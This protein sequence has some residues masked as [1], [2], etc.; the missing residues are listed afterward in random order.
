MW[1]GRFNPI[2]VTDREDELRRLVDLFRVDLLWPI[3]ET[4]DNAKKFLQK[5]PY[6]I[7]PFIF[8]SPF[9]GEKE[10]KRAQLLDIHNMLVYLRDKPEWEALNTRGLRVYTWKSDDPLA[11]VF[12]IQLGAYPDPKE[13]GIEY[14]EMLTEA[15][16]ATEHQLESETP[17]PAQV[18]DHPNIASLSRHGLKQHY[19]VRNDRNNPGFFAG[20]ATNLEDL[21]C[22]WNLRAANV[23]LLFVD[24]N[25]APRYTTIIPEWEKW[26]REMVAGRHEWDRHVS[27]WSRRDN[28]EELLKPFGEMRLTRCRVSAPLWNG[29]NVRAPMMHF[30]ETSVLGVM[31]K[32]SGKPKVSFALSDKPFSTDHWFYTQHLAASLSFS[33]GLYD[34]E[35]HTLG[36][37]YLPEL[38]EFYSRSM[39]FHY[40]KLRIEPERIGLV[41]DVRDHDSFLYALPV[42]DLMTRIFDMAG[43][44]S[45]LSSGG[46]ITRQL[47]ARLGGID[48]ARPF[49]IPGVRRLLKTYGPTAAF[50]KSTALQLIGAKDPDN[51][52]AQF[53][54][55]EDLF[56][57]ARPHD[58]KLKPIDAFTYLVD[59]G[60]FR[61]GVQLT[62]PNCR[63]ASWTPLDALKQQVVCELCGQEHDST[64]QKIDGEWH[65]RRTGILGAEKNAQGAVPV[66]LTLQRLATTIERLLEGSVYSPSLDL[67]PKD[68]MDRPTCEVDFVWLIP[69]PYPRKTVVI[70]A[71]CKDQLPSIQTT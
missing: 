63:M 33:G 71:E 42:A 5:F 49:K 62:C 4:E 10:H 34:D 40:D 57:E 41:I 43:F 29:K 52:G 28:M 19:G 45:Q 24:S 21:I 65:Y 64:R 17:I 37:P 66:I 36:P 27:V 46:L 59:K 50:T 16:E 39:H 32:E 54:D 51:P 56:I 26:I 55:H 68:G 8:N 20:D 22:F 31:T 6:L 2:L 18:L 11:D 9:I 48:G 23:A 44:S 3:G 25:H 47:I 1:G 70:L 14:L 53:S 12:L 69:R 61:I 7:K 58:T 60:L 30:G 13:T 15:A 67:V 35:H 38:N